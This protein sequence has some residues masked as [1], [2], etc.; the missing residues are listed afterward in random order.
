MAKVDH[1]YFIW[2]HPFDNGTDMTEESEASSVLY[3]V[4]EL[5]R[6]LNETQLE[7]SDIQSRKSLLIEYTTR[8]ETSTSSRV[9][10]K[11]QMGYHANIS[12]MIWLKM[13]QES[14]EKLPWIGISSGSFWKDIIDVEMR[15]LIMSLM[16]HLHIFV[17][18]DEMLFE[19]DQS[20]ST[21]IL[22]AYVNNYKSLVDTDSR[23]FSFDIF[24]YNSSRQASIKELRDTLQI[25]LRRIYALRLFRIEEILMKVNIRKNHRITMKTKRIHYFVSRPSIRKMTR[26][27]TM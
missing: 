4:V 15:T 26:C 23:L 25:K 17:I 20:E 13:W 12:E 6:L 16:F 8:T 21:N 24:S 14:V 2:L 7:S 3:T 19:E 9:Y 22:Q 11:A 27:T 10:R 18:C 1:V 5:M